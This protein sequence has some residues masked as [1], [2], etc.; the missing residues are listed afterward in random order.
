MN[1]LVTCAACRKPV[2]RKAA[3][4]VNGVWTHAD[5]KCLGLVY[6]RATAALREIRRQLDLFGK[7]RS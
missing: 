5:P 1:P 6:R 3:V 2:L 7:G 4:G